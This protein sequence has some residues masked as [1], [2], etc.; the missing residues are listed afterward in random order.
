MADKDKHDEAQIVQTKAYIPSHT[1]KPITW[2]LNFSGLAT[3][4]VE[5]LLSFSRFH[6]GGRCMTRKKT[7]KGN[8]KKCEIRATI[9]IVNFT[10]LTREHYA[11]FSYEAFHIS[12]KTPIR[13][14]R[15]HR[16][17]ECKSRPEKKTIKWNRNDQTNALLNPAHVSETSRIIRLQFDCLC[18]FFFI[19]CP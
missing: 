13:I 12:R 9:T 6:L 19:F 7:K 4:L 8:S 17:S 11:H 3:F 2:L 14:H 15:L 1:P 10:A 16:P 18:V 5:V